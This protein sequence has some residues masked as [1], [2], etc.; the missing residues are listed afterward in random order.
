MGIREDIQ[1]EIQHHKDYIFK[2]VKAKDKSKIAIH[3][4]EIRKWTKN[5][6][7]LDELID[8]VKLDVRHNTILE[9]QSILSII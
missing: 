3:A 1:H 9:I 5:L 4:N 8:Q 7:D 2:C 6:E